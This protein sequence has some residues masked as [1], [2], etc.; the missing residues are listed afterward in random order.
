MNIKFL[1]SPG[2]GSRWQSRKVL[3]TPPLMDTAKLQLHI[4]QLSLRMT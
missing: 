2:V 4:E 3:S 1:N